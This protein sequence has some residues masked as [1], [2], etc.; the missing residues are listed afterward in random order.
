MNIYTLKNYSNSLMHQNCT[1]CFQFETF[2]SIFD[3]FTFNLKSLGAYLVLYFHLL[4]NV[5]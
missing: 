1:M 2:R 3:P 4:S 5:V